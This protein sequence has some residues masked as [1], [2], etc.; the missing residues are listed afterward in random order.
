MNL[1]L[2]V[3]DIVARTNHCKCAMDVLMDVLNSWYII[4]I[5]ECMSIMRG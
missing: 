1:T 2:L 3:A 5:I 4:G